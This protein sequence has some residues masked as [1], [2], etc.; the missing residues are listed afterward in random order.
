VEGNDL[1]SVWCVA[2]RLEVPVLC[3]ALAFVEHVGDYSPVV[4]SRIR[5]E[6]LLE[7]PHHLIFVR[8]AM[9]P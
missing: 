3:F 5:S 4:D 9:I 2:M 8:A 7:V 6:L 1:G